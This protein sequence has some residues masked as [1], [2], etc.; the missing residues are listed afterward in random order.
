MEIKQVILVRRDLKMPKGKMA[1]QVG[2]GCVDCALLAKKNKNQIFNEWYESG[3]KKV[4]LYVENLDEMI[5]FKNIFD[6]EN[7]INSM[8]KDAGR[9]CFSQPT[10]TVLAVGPEKEEELDKFVKDLKLV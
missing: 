9:T 1:A 6:R 8:I 5:K 2:H 7:I 3:M 4:V 10:I